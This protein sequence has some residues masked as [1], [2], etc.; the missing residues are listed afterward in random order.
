MKI[1]F[2]TIAFL[3][4][5]NLI[6]QDTLDMKEV[7]IDN[8]LV[9]RFSNDERFTGVAQ[10]KRKNGH[11]IYEEHYNDG[12]ILED[13]TYYN[14]K[15]KILAYKTIYHKYKLWVP[16]KEYGYPKSRKWIDV[17]TYD[18][19]GKKILVE[20]FENDKLTYRCEYSGKKKHGKEFCYSD[21]GE[22]LHFEY[23]NGKKKK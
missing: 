8:D 23:I 22:E 9:Y 10:V 14:G 15:E 3:L 12:V 13:F 11:L 21:N 17:I 6:G 5:S 16:K 2:I 1:I 19:T 7:Y 20:Q 4:S 18:E